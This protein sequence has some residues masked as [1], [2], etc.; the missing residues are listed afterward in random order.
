MTA[1]SI[2]LARVKLKQPALFIACLTM[3]AIAGCTSHGNPQLDELNDKAYR[4]HY[5]SLDSVGYYA[6]R[7]CSMAT[8]DDRDQ[9]AEAHNNLAFRA[10]MRMA[11]ATADYHL[12]LIPQLTDNQIELLVAYIQHMRLCQRQSHNREF[13]DYRE[14][15]INALK[16]INE[17][18]YTLT[19][20]QQRRLRYAESELAIVNS[21]YYYYI[22]LEQQSIDALADLPDDLS[23]DTAQW[24]NYLYNVGAGGVITDG[25]QAQVRQ[26]EMDHLMRCYQ[27]AEAHHYPYFTANALEAMADHLIDPDSRQQLIAAN[28]AGL[29][30]VCGYDVDTS[31]G[32]TEA[33]VL[34][35]VLAERSLALFTDY[36]DVY[37]IAGAYRTLASCYRQMGDHA[38]TLA[39]LQQALAD[40]L[41]NQAPDLVASIREQLSVAYAAVNDKQQSD[42]NRNLYLDL[43]EETRQ[44]RQLEARAAQYDRTIAQQ[45]RLIAAVVAAIVLLLFLLWLFNHLN[46]RHPGSHHQLGDALEEQR[47][48]LA[49][50]R[51]QVEK[52]ERTNLEQRARIALVNSITPLIDRM[53]LEERRLMDHSK[54]NETS[55]DENNSYRL[56][57]IREITDKI[58]A[59][60]ATLTNWI[61]L[62]Q[63]ELSL[64]IETF[65]LQPL[66]DMVARSTMAFKLKGV[67]LVVEPTTAVVKADRI[68]T[69]FMLNT[70]A[71][72]ARKFTPDG[73]RVAISADETDS[74]VELTVEDSGQGMTQEQIDH[75]F[76]HKPIVDDKGQQPTLQQPSHGFGLLN[77]KGIIEKYRKLS[78]LFAV[79]TIQAE[80]TLGK[81]SRLAFRL[82]KGTLR[83][84]LPI[85]MIAL[86][87]AAS[88][89]TATPPPPDNLARASIYADSA[90]F[91]N[92]NGNYERTLLFADS[93]RLFLNRHYTQLHPKGNTLML[94]EGDMTGLAP[95]IQWLHDSIDTNYNIILDIRNESAV[96]ALALHQWQLYAYNNR[97]YT[98]L[99]KE[100]SADSSL[101]EYCRSMQ[102]AQA[103]KAV[104]VILLL[105]LLIAI[106]PAYYFLYLR[107]RLRSRFQAERIEQ[108]TL[109]TLADEK[110]RADMEQATLHVANAV[111]DNCLSTLKHETMY[112]PSRIRQLLD[113]AHDDDY[114]SLT[115]VTA[116]YRE[117]YALLSEQAMNQIEHTKLHLT[118]LDHG[119]LGDRNL[120]DY[121]FDILRKQA[122]ERKLATTVV[123]RDHTY[124]HLLADMP[125]L[126]L[127]ADE[128][129]QLFTP[130]TDNIPYLLCRQIV[131]DHGEATNRRG[132]SIRAEVAADGH[133]QIHIVLPSAGK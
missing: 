102:K 2:S 130:S 133:T 15:A 39:C 14:R 26:Q 112:Y 24:L 94:A 21:T 29:R 131:R 70:L 91:S 10:I 121:L 123:S 30:L 53:L 5:R 63:G 86:Q 85:A 62:R 16:R 65:A 44:D 8:N 101:P 34:P 110:A 90:Y 104:A 117:L 3:L 9:L 87:A 129:Q 46:H 42:I 50:A 79:C 28:S 47:E 33:M 115:E 127:T 54:G 48:Q 7:V 56:E 58:N 32:S 116:Y 38:T 105:L 114:R 40:T 92:I 18:R 75:L 132:C 43:Q 41:V 88:A 113:H 25:T 99:F 1:A 119:I 126:R 95:E 52:L 73:G 109:D 4:C 125:K 6:G 12:S 17:E 122:G 36:G 59:D 89:Q 111:L 128:A 27:I 76:D 84:L 19:P 72:N 60:N 67:S 45:N 22:G 69:L 71:D 98:L 77:C 103:N 74:Y 35:A 108:Q 66:F 106:V 37:Q 51:R 11:Y 96:A 120:V 31:D 57:Y 78:Q 64:H 61:Q 97:I 68:L 55:I 83:L 124:V 23:Q 81:G 80:S 82:P 49:L 13:Y 100:M 93:C 20:R 107:P 118:P